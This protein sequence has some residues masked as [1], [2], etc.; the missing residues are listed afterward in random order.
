MLGVGAAMAL[1]GCVDM[2]TGPPPSDAVAWKGT[3]T[4]GNPS[5]PECGSFALELGQY[6]PPTF[7]W[8]TV[9]GRAWPTAVPETQLGRWAAAYRQWW[10]EG[11]VTPANFVEFETKLQQPVYFRARPYSV[12]RGTITDDRMVLTESGSPCNREAVLVRG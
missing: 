8:N 4:E 9:S 1:G 7:M 2:F 6:Q 3:T 10:L 11:Y 12:W 5:Y